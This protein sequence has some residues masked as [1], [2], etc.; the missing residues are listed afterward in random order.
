MGSKLLLQTIFCACVTHTHLTWRPYFPSFDGF[1]RFFQKVPFRNGTGNGLRLCCISSLSD[2]AQ[3][4]GM[5]PGHAADR[6]I[7]MPDG[8]PD[9]VAR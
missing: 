2:V 5:L 3:R 7:G 8:M 1:L 6:Q 4:L 9:A